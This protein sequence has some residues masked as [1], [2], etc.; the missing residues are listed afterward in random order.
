MMHRMFTVAGSFLINHLPTLIIGRGFHST[1]HTLNQSNIF[2]LK[3]GVDVANSLNLLFSR[4]CRL[5]EKIKLLVGF[6]RA[7]WN[8]APHHEIP[9]TRISH[10]GGPLKQ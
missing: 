1:L 5:K 3:H 2:R 4:M 8:K 10:Q 6:L 7:C 9:A